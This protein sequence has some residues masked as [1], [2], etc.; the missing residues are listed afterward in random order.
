ME[1]ILIRTE[2]IPPED[3]LN[4]FV[5]TDDDR[6]IIDALKGRQPCILVGSR[7]VGKSLLLKVA[8]AEL[9]RAFDEKK[10]LPVYV[11][12]VSSPLL[13][14]LEDIHVNAWM[15]SKIFSAIVR[16]INKFGVGSFSDIKLVGF[17]Q[18]DK[19]VGDLFT[20]LD[21][22]I[23]QLEG[24][25][26]D[27]N[28]SIDSSSA[29]DAEKLKEVVGNI[30]EQT[31]ISRIV[32]LIDEASHIFLPRQQRLFFSLFRD[33][34]SPHLNCK[35]AVYPGVTSYGPNFQ[36]THDA[37]FLMTERD[38]RSENYQISMRQIALKQVSSGLTRQID[39]YGRNFSVLAYAAHGNPRTLLKS[40]ASG[41]KL[42]TSEINSYIKEYYRAEVWS[43][44]SL[45]GDKYKGH[46]SLIDWARLFIEET[47]LPTLTKK[48]NDSATGQSAYFWIHR[49]AP[50][51]VHQAMALLK[52]TGIVQEHM[53][54]IK[55]PVGDIGT[56]YIVNL[57]CLFSLH[58][59]PVLSGV[60]LA[61]K[62]D[63]RRYIEFDKNHSAF[64]KDS[65]E[66]AS[67]DENGLNSSILANQ[68]AKS[69]EVLDLTSFQ[70][71]TIISIGLKTIEDILKASDSRIQ[72]ARGI[73]VARTRKIK[74]AAHAA[75]FE[76]LSG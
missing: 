25:W 45:L 21:D 51:Y 58:A 57:G 41:I 32:L 44:H 70:K 29:P 64:N 22:L 14:G 71:K 68:L 40:L 53:A 38:V 49:D 4:I 47:V 50:A 59:D 11:S 27:P 8:Q 33:L 37:T 15:L 42:N 12:F 28:A 9:K 62:L 18:K 46:R 52:Y 73:G 67:L 24:A 7:G 34:R 35:A 69:I 13:Q 43:E 36:P 31:G 56:K 23:E 66:F 55:N 63:D 5:E 3:I 1:D 30:C 39:Q 48:N 60:E 17:R 26:N 61:S 65:R 16:E 19:N 6:S 2:D 20:L 74:N 54:A 76:Y 10:I 75:V 72:E